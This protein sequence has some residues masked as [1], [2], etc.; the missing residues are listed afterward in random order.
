MR[1]RPDPPVRAVRFADGAL[2]AID[3]TRLPAELSELELR[4]ADAVDKVG[5]YGHALA[6]PPE[7]ASV[8]G[9]LGSG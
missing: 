9:L 8:L 4:D 3:Q 5:T 6:R 7:R 2:W 1:D